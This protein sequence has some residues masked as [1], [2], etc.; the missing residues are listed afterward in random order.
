MIRGYA[1]WGLLLLAIP[2]CDRAGE[3]EVE[4]R[5]HASALEQNLDLGAYLALSIHPE[6]GLLKGI[7]LPAP[8]FADPDRI[9]DVVHVQGG[10]ETP[11]LDGVEDAKFLGDGSFVVISRQH[12]LIHFRN[13]ESRILA[14]DVY[15]P[16]SVVGQRV[17]YLS[18]NAMPFFVPA[19]LDVQSGERWVGSEDLIP[20]WSPVLS[21]DSS[22]LMFVSG[23]A[24]HA[25]LLR[26]T[27]GDG[28]SI[29]E[30]IDIEAPPA[31]QNA[32]IWIQPDILLFESEEEGTLRYH[33]PTNTTTTLDGTLP[34][35]SSDGRVY[36]HT[37]G[38]LREHRE[39]KR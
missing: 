39:V 9:M 17:A 19:V 32:P 35:M 1:I 34:L 11:V 10:K 38:G 15:G 31:G 22:E 25:Q 14:T 26:A 23:K 6:G 3:T 27:L 36:L 2:A 13:K 7:V 5:T 24:G 18:G 16:L 33:L 21:P 4:S 29:R 37:D 28:L 30:T 12:E 20:S 8:E